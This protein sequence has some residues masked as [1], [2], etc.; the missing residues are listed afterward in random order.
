M[1]RYAVVLLPDDNG[2]VM[3]T[4]PDFPEAQTFG[5]DEVEALAHASEA[6]ATIVDGYIRARRPLPQPSATSGPTAE[7]SALMSA[8][9]ELY[10]AMQAL[11]V[12]KSDLGRRLNWHSPQVDRLLNLTHSSQLDQL[13][14]AVKVLGGRLSVRIDGLPTTRPRIVFEVRTQKPTI[15]AA[16]KS[17]GRPAKRPASR[18]RHSHVGEKRPLAAKKK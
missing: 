12:T 11:G 3:V 6:L 10:N 4:F 16:V 8:K 9:V 17:S 15:A 14:A 18:S 1:V 2:T 5:E 13:D 7:L